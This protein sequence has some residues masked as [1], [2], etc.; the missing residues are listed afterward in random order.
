MAEAGFPLREAVAALAEAGLLAD[1]LLPD[2]DGWR[3]GTA[4][5]LPP[6]AAFLGATLDSRAV[7]AGQLFVALPGERTDGRRYLGAALAAGAAAVL[8]PPGE[9]LDAALRA[10]PSSGGPILVASDGVAA[11]Q[12]LAA[13]W[14]RRCPVPLLAITG[15]NGKTTTK[16]LAA[17]LLRPRGAVLATPGNRNNDLGLPLTL[18][19]LR[20][21]HRTAVVEMGASRAGEIARL[22]ALAT[23][24][25]GVITNVAPAHLEGFGSQAEIIAAKGELL[26]ALPPDGTAVLNADSPG[27]AAWRERAR[28][29]IVSFGRTAGDHRWDWSPADGGRRGDLL[30]DGRRYPVPL[31]GPHNGANLAAALLAV[32][33]LA[34]EPSDVAAALD[35]FVPSAHRSRLLR[36]GGITLLDDS[37][38]ANPQSILAAARSLLQLPG[39]RSWVVLGV[40][41]ELG[42]RSRELHVQTGRRLRELGV[43]RLVAVG[44]AAPLAEGFRD[45][46]GGEAAVVPDH[47]AAAAWLL[48]RL[49]RGDRVL[50]KGSRSAATE[51]IVD[52]LVAGLGTVEGH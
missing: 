24:Q 30:L 3:R 11:L 4:D 48:E 1:L 20:R 45:V 2:S 27:F 40:M 31:P 21:D 29:R 8:A 36:A 47:A 12:R 49:E 15:T 44:E 22:A 19:A 37:Y 42:E 46:G 23:P 41:A 38:N 50:V 16:D 52:R 35:G 10:A 51:R 14:R 7:A 17:A 13:G 28:C 18:L 6:G 34:G 43:D 25:V 26:D 5:E 33:A 9:P 32:R 39:G